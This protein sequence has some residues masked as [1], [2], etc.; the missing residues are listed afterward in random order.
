MRR[1]KLISS[2]AWDTAI[3]LIQITNEDY[4]SSSIEGNYIEATFEYTDI[5]GIVKTKNKNSVT[6]VPTGETTEVCNIYDMGGNLLEYTTENS[7]IIGVP[8]AD[9][10]GHYNIG[11]EISPASYRD[12]RNGSTYDGIGFRITL[13]L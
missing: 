13:F 6:L 1:T 2:Y 9:R 5:T 10:G 4:G 8:Y 11:Y 3:S 7:S 12:C